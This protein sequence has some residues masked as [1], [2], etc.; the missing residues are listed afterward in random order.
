[1]RIRTIKPD[2]W[3]HEGMCSCSEF[4]RLLAIALLNWAD[5]EGY[6]MANP[7][8]LRGNLFPFLDSSKI[9]PGALLELSK[10]GWI[11]LGIDDQ[12]RHVGVIQNFAKHQRVDKPKPSEIK[13]SSSFQDESKMLPGF[14]LE[15][16]LLEGKGKEEKGKDADAPE[17]D[18]NGNPFFIASYDWP[19]EWSIERVMA[20]E[21][22]LVYRKGIRKAVKPASLP[23][24]IKQHESLNDQQFSLCLTTSIANGWQGSFPDKVLNGNIRPQ[25]AHKLPTGV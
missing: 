4:A 16:S 20:A 1:M 22:W 11:Q 10:V 19:E 7:S 17:L 25:P 8:L 13:A 2:F 15:S 14:V 12:G 9:I 5:D 24:W 3:I 18:E 21:E 6:F 23:A